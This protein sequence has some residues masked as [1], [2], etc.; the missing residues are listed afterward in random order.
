[1]EYK[2]WNKTVLLLD[3]ALFSSD[4]EYVQM[5]RQLALVRAYVIRVDDEGGWK[6]LQR[7]H[8]VIG[9]IQCRR[10]SVVNVREQR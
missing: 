5:A 3:K 4:I 10:C 8:W 6:W 1:M 9:L 7:W 2:E